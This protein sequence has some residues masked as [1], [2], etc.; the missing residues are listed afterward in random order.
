RALVP[1]AFADGGGRFRAH[2]RRA[3]RAPLLRPRRGHDL[4][5]HLA[6]G[7]SHAPMRRLLLLAVL[8]ALALP[9]QA[10]AHATLEQASPGFG[11]R[12]AAA[13]KTLTLQFDQYVIALPGSVPLLSA[14][15]PIGVS[16]VRDDSRLL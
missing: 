2:V 9:A 10:L 8:A 11:A 6:A 7:R 5:A 14:A 1:S 3:R 13:P 15:A 4:R 16:N 12:V